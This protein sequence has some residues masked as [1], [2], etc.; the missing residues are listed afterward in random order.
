MIRDN[1]TPPIGMTGLVTLEFRDK[2][3]CSCCVPADFHQACVLRWNRPLQCAVDTS[4]CHPLPPPPSRRP[5]ACV[6][7]HPPILHLVLPDESLKGQADVYKILEGLVPLQ[8]NVQA[9]ASRQVSHTLVYLPS[10]RLFILC[11]GNHFPVLV[12]C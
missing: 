6:P 3:Y 4:N 8:V 7:R 12:L 10:C 9:V 2:K 11:T 5:T 1:T